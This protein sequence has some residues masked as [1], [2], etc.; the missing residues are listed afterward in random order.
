[1]CITPTIYNQTAVGTVESIK[2]IESTG[3]VLVFAHLKLNHQV[4]MMP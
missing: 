1:G 3:H 2:W 4:R